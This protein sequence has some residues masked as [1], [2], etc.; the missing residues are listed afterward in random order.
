MGY[1]HI[2]LFVLHT[3]NPPTHTCKEA[4]DFC[5]AAMLRFLSVFG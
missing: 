2:G 5:I 1:D 3:L 4:W